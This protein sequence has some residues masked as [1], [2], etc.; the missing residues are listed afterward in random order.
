M[1]E[2]IER[3]LAPTPQHRQRMQREGRRAYSAELTGAAAMVAAALSI[4][5]VDGPMLQACVGMVEAGL[6]GGVRW[7]PGCCGSGL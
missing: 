6:S 4:A 1:S 2:P 7:F 5:W 3:T